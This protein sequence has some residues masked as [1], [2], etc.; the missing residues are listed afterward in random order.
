MALPHVD[1]IS[2]T[3][4]VSDDELELP[5]HL[6]EHDGRAISL[7]LICADYGSSNRRRGS[8]AS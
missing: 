4:R 2:E 8:Q 7:N 6:P 5:P 1:E 3:D